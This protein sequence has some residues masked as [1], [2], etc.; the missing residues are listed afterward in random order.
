MVL[1][2][3]ALRDEAVAVLDSMDPARLDARLLFIHGILA[4]CLSR[5]RQSFATYKRFLKESGGSE[6]LPDIADLV[7]GCH[8]PQGRLPSWMDEWRVP[9]HLS[10]ARAVVSLRIVRL[11]LGTRVLG[12]EE[13][14]EPLPVLKAASELDWQQAV[15]FAEGPVAKLDSPDWLTF[16][17]QHPGNPLV[18]PM[19]L[20]SG[21][22]ITLKP[23][24]VRQLLKGDPPLPPVFELAV[25]R[26][27]PQDD[28][29]QWLARLDRDT[30]SDPAFGDGAIVLVNRLLSDEEKSDKPGIFGNRDLA[31]AVIALGKAGF[32]GSRA[33]AVH[34]MNARVALLEGDP[35]GFLNHLAHAMEAH[36]ERNPGAL[37]TVPD[38]IYGHWRLALGHWRRLKG[39]AAL[40]ELLEKVPSPALRCLFAMV[41]PWDKSISLIRDELDSLPSDMP[42][43]LRRDLIR[44]RWDRDVL[45]A[46]REKMMAEWQATSRDDADPRLAL[47]AL[48]QSAPLMKAG[49]IPP[50]PRMI[51]L[52]ER[53]QG[54]SEADRRFADRYVR[55]TSRGDVWPSGP[56]IP[57][58][59][60]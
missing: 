32:T 20:Q 21:Q 19:L 11:T 16:F 49:M 39:D 43:P 52:L 30:W 29:L 34:F 12:W 35:D 8:A 31:A 15:A 53:L 13:A 3:A 59:E 27:H 5:D 1:D 14:C 25:R 2:R 44:L 4:E 33:A 22:L 18:L 26:F 48:L 51:G 55:D 24:Q 50:S 41:G 37:E 9:T 57:R 46:G 36:D 47:E 38:A 40:S 45:G 56:T 60:R 42:R 7:T 58:I 17:G 23:P 54:S 28:T 10:H 6:H